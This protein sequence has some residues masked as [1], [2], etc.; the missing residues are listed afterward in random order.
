V[1]RSRHI[2]AKKNRLTNVIVT[3]L[4][5]FYRICRFWWRLYRFNIGNY[6]SCFSQL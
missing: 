5:V 6:L 2:Y 3:S 4:S 1:S